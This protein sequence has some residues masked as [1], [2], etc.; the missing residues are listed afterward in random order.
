MSLASRE[1]TNKPRESGE[2]RRKNE[3]NRDE[4]NGTLRKEKNIYA[5]AR[6]N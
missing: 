1:L 4:V 3:K 6:Q 5:N 2:E